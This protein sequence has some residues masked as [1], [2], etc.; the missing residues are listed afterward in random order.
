MK[1]SYGGFLLVEDMNFQVGGLE[2]TVSPLWLCICLSLRIG[3][4]SGHWEQLLLFGD[5][6]HRVCPFFC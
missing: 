6:L 2:L 4:N 3:L 5:K 1:S